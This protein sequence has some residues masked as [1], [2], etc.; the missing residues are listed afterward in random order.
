VLVTKFL[1]ISGGTGKAGHFRCYGAQ[2]RNC[3]VYT[4]AASGIVPLTPA[5]SLMNRLNL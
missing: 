3:G 5:V 2:S 1:S 4:L